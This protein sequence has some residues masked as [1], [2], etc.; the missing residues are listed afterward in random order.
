MIGF[1]VNNSYFAANL[2]IDTYHG[3]K[4]AKQSDEISAG[5]LGSDLPVELRKGAQ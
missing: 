3:K 2:Q 5:N 4:M 1:H